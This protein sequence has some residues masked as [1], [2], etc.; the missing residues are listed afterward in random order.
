LPSFLLLMSMLNLENIFTNRPCWAI[1]F[2]TNMGDASYATYL[3]HYY[4]VEL[5]R[6]IGFQK[7]NLINP[8]APLG[9]ALIVLTSLLVGHLLYKWVDK[10]LTRY[11][12]VRRAPTTSTPQGAALLNQ[13]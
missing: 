8:Y 10:P 6:K 7:F 12:K 13:D 9:V 1:R 3:S 4:V 11:V 2:C 5:V